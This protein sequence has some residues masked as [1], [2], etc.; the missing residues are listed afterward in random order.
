MLSGDF[1]DGICNVLHVLGV[2]AGNGY[3]SI[4]GS[5]DPVLRMI[6]QIHARINVKPTSFANCCICFA[7]KPV[8]AN[9]PICV[10]Q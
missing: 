9:I 7:V 2:D 5:V 10:R 8:Y 1:V 4:Q 3:S 6:S